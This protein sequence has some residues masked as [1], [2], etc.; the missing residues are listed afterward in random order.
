MKFQLFTTSLLCLSL[1][2]CGSSGGSSSTEMT[3]FGEYVYDY[4]SYQDALDN[5]DLYQGDSKIITAGE[6]SDEE[7]DGFYLDDVSNQM[8]FAIDA[9]NNYSELRFTTDFNSDDD[10]FYRLLAELLPLT[11]TDEVITASTEQQVTLLQVAND[12]GYAPLVKIIWDSATRDN[13]SNSYWAVVNT[14]NCTEADETTSCFSYTYLMDY[15]A[16]SP[17][18]FEILVEN[19]QLSVDVTS[20]N[21]TAEM[22][23]TISD[24]ADISQYF[25]AGVSNEDANSTTTVQFK[26][27]TYN[28]NL[29]E[30]DLSVDAK[31]SENFDLLDWYLSVPDDRGNGTATSIS[32]N[33][34]DGYENANYFYTNEE[35]G[36]MVFV[37]PIA[38]AKTSTN[39]SYTRTELREMLSRGENTSASSMENNW[40]FSSAS[41]DAQDD[42][43]AVDGVLEATLAVNHVTTTGDSDQRGRVIVGQIHATDDEPIRLYYRLL[44]GHSKGSIYFAHEPRS[45]S[46]QWIEMIG[47]KSDSASEPS[48]GIALDEKFYYKIKVQGNLLI[49]TIKRDYKDDITKTWDMSASGF[50]D[51]D[52]YMY[53]KAG[54]YNQNKSGDDDDFVQATFYYLDNQHTGYSYDE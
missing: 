49:V 21:S 47:S 12:E 34:L 43:A 45:G 44:P 8:T 9:E 33:S 18:K 29:P 16:T 32:A 53:F 17:T 26:T 1:T 11:E 10:D 19:N 28:T 42:A 31:P 24:W 38:G 5:A 39:T 40:V 23:L 20:A 36:G 25:T 35:N 13:H 54:V 27:L 7:T 37:C 22:T 15:D 46:E 52:Q 4:P 2:A 30:H 14:G 3:Y 50:D 48:D 6:Y 41:K 51:D